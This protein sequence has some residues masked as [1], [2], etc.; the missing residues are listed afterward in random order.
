MRNGGP[1]PP[2][3]IESLREMLDDAAAT[4][5]AVHIVHITSMGL[6]QTKDCLA[7]IEQAR[8][9]GLDVTT[10][11][12]P[13]TAGMTDLA[14]AIFDEGWQQRQGNITYSD[15]QWAATGER[16]TPQTFARYR[17]QGGYVAIH[18][19]PENIVQLAMSHPLVMIASD[20]ILN[21]GKGHPRAAGTYA[22]VLGR[23]VRE[24]HALS[25]M[26]AIRKM[27]LMPANRLGMTNKGR[28]AAGADAD[29]TIFDPARVTDRATFDK[30]AQY[31]DGIPYVI[32]AGTPVV[33]H[34]ELVAGAVP[35]RAVRR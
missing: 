18:S 14:S 35:G 16:L 32:V 6:A 1:V 22:R 9:R 27:S 21:E 11:A 20:G 28:I 5:A 7:M 15:L 17:K 30:P 34:G 12:Y 13:Y 3:A 4:K 19:I 31:S 2:G 29:L 10:E 33:D 23:Y 25:L 26:D 24:K 8:A